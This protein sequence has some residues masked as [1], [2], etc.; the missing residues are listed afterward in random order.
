MKNSIEKGL[1]INIV[2]GYTD[3]VHCL[4]SLDTNRSIAETM[5]M[6]KGESAYWANKNNLTE[7]KLAW[8][9]E[10][11][12]ISV[13]DSAFSIVK[14]YIKNQEKHHSEKSLDDELV[15]SGFKMT[16]DFSP[17]N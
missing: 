3:H 6:I 10:Y 11:Y 16:Q 17:T 1:H 15:D 14:K 12:A 4:F 9:K 2:N 7:K 8:A 5:K 13:S